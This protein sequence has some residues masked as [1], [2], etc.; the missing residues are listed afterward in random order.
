MENKVKQINANYLPQLTVTG[1]TTYRAGSHQNCDSATGCAAVPAKKP[2]QYSF[3]LEVRQNLFDFGAIRTQKELGREDSDVQVQQ[4]D[5]EYG[6]VKG[7]SISCWEHLPATK[8]QD[9]ELRI[10]E[11][12]QSKVNPPS[13]MERHCQKQLARA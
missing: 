6:K 7:A 13:P 2:D 9:Q 11:L 4:L 8:P 1:Q 5:V 3:G 10:E 12:G